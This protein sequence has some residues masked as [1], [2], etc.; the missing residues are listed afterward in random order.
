[1]NDLFEHLHSL[2]P[3]LIISIL[4]I[5]LVSGVAPAMFL[6]RPCWRLSARITRNSEYM[7]F[8]NVVLSVD[9]VG[10][11]ESLPLEGR[12][13]AQMDATLIQFLGIILFL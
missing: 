13:P 5:F 1:M 12:T 9:P 4:S 7:R 8:S 11:H 3:L 6:S 10:R 2:V